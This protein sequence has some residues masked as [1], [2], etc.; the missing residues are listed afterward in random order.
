MRRGF[1]FLAIGLVM[2]SMLAAC[3]GKPTTVVGQA[4]GAAPTEYANR[5]NPLA[6]QA[7]AAAVGGALYTQYC[8]ACHGATG[9]GDGAAGKALEP[10]PGNLAAATAKTDGELYWRIAEGGAFAPF[11]SAMLSWKAAL[12]EVQI[13][14]LVS[15]IRTLK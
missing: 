8:A 9:L 14:Q 6:G 13:W 3:G 15:Y 1:A 11:N 4:G 10:K 5:I 12:T 2:V 7:E